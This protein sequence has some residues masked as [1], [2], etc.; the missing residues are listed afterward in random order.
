MPVMDGLEATEKIMALEVGTPIV[1]MT[2]NIMSH[3]V[4]RYKERGMS[5]HVSKPFTSQELWTCLLKYFK[6]INWNEEDEAQRKSDDNELR[7]KLINKFVST[8][9]NRFS[10]IIE[11]IKAG[12]IKQAHRMARQKRLQ[13]AAAAVESMVSGGKNTLTGG[14]L[15]TLRREL[16]IV[17]D[18]LAPEQADNGGDLVTKATRGEMPEELYEKL[19]GLFLKRN[20][21]CFELID[22]LVLYEKTGELVRLI[23]DY[24]FKKAMLELIRLKESGKQT[25]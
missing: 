17:L 4:E 22:E 5:A 16:R 9:Q 13:E 8:N 23:S 14:Y 11:T 15:E 1:A 21:A 12:D 18:E 6:P 24:D 19:K 2:A 7:E 10:E 25:K 3:D 20:P